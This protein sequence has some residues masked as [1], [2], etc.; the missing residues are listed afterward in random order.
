[1]ATQIFVGKLSFDTTDD[2]LRTLFAQYG[3]VASA[4]VIIDRATN[5]SKGFAFV[6]M[7]DPKEAQDAITAL[8]GK[9]FEGR[10]LAVNVARPRE[11]RPQG[12]NNF[13]GGFQP[14]R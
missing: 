13:S 4:R 5:R 12:G 10:T 11:E 3:T 14:R 8:D 7:E 1:M 6:E 9:D 2:A